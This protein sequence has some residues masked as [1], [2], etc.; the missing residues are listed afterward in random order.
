MTR[1]RPL[2]GNV[3]L[4]ASG[5]RLRKDPLKSP[6]GGWSPHI[7]ALSIETIDADHFR[8]LSDD[9]YVSE[10]ADILVKH[11]QEQG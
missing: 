3:T 11:L 9:P 8:M 10:L 6:T 2:A 5:A 7:P 4:I 1:M